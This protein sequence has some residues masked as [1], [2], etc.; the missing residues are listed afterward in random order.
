MSKYTFT[1]E[2]LKTRLDKHLAERLSEFS[3]SRIQR[4]IEAEQVT[5]N[6]KIIKEPKHVVRKGDKIIYKPVAAKQKLKPVNVQLK[7]LYNDH[8]LLIIDKPPGLVVHP[9]AGFKGDS[10]ADALLYQFKDI[11]LVG[12]EGRSGIVHRLDKDTS[13][14]M[15]IA[16][17]QPMYE[18]LKDAFA[19]RKIKKEY[20]ALVCGKLVKQ[21]GFIDSPLGKSKTDF[22]KMSTKNFIEAKESLTEYWVLEH[23]HSPPHEGEREGVLANTPSSTTSPNP[24]SRGGEFSGVDSY[25]LVRV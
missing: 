7:T 19:E 9:G 5:V 20:I 23:L 2:V 17:T 25:T 24:S 14:V 13:G 16:L 18:Y 4:D 15:L 12:E 3:R 6:G 8:G 10:L 11:K 21:H 22:R 1:V